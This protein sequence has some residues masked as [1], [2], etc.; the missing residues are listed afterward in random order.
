[1]V[2]RTDLIKDLVF[3]PKRGRRNVADVLR[4]VLLPSH[5]K[6][7]HM[8]SAAAQSQGN[9]LYVV[10]GFVRDLLLEIPSADYDSINDGNLIYMR[11]VYDQSQIPMWGQEVSVQSESG[12]PLSMIALTFFVILILSSSLFVIINKYKKSDDLIL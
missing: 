3:S 11:P 6:L 4:H 1:M 8:V 12:F 2:T 5:L 10:G 9:G 7:L